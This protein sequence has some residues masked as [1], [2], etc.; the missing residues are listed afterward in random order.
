M[1]SQVSAGKTR[2]PVD[3]T[4]F[5]V[6][7]TILALLFP[8]SLFLAAGRL[9]WPMGWMY[10]VLAVGST[11]ISRYLM[12]RQNP[13]LFEER[14]TAM[15][16]EDTKSW[17]KFLVPIVTLGPLV[18]IIVAGLDFR[19]DWSPAFAS[20]VEWLGAALMLLGYWF[21]G[22][23]MVTN[24]FYSSAVRLQTDRGQHVV[25]DGPYRIVRHPSYLGLLIGSLGTA[26]VLSSVW[27]LIPA[28][29]VLIVLIMRTSLEDSTL[30]D[31]LPGYRDYAQT[32]RYRL[33]PGV[34]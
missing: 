16:R 24:A 29:A 15:S 32:T 23:A 4:K 3:W 1:M 19:N 8:L 31:E 22:W 21:A 34:W 9:D 13:E 17:D 10:V 12:I 28:V 30:H 7:M 2:V 26:L 5:V 20:W 18:Q 33:L 27:S 11:V 25:T 14:S 6:R